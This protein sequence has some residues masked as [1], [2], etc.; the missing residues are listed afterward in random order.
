MCPFDK[1]IVLQWKYKYIPVKADANNAI[2][3]LPESTGINMVA[4][5]MK[6]GEIRR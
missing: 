2:R 1:F 6:T 5:F 4:K 3:I